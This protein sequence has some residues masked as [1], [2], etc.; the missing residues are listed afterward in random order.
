[1]VIGSGPV[2]PEMRARLGPAAFLGH[3]EGEAL[4]RAVA[5][6]DILLNPSL[7]EAFG[8]VNLE[9]MAAGLA[10]VSAD[11]GSAQALIENGRSGILCAPDPASYADA[12]ESL[13]K[14]PARRMALGRAASASAAT[15]RWP[16]VLEEVV[17]AYKSLLPPIAT[18]S[19]SLEMQAA[20]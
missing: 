5:S 4:G 11:V 14:D 9:A 13:V 15:F 16:L 19:R 20:A 8:N 6:A 1:M 12:I 7:T 10:V 17:G 18:M 3:L 2:E